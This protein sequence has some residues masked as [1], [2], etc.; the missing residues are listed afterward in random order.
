[1]RDPLE[2]PQIY[3][4]RHAMA[5]IV[6]GFVLGFAVWVIGYVQGRNDGGQIVGTMVFSG[7][8]VGFIVGW[9]RVMGEP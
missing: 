4:Q 3:V 8:G 7:W 1:M 6:I 2:P 5:G 9:L